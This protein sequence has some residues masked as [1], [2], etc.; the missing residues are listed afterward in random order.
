LLFCPLR[1]PQSGDWKSFGLAPGNCS[2]V[3]RR[4]GA[5]Q[6]PGARTCDQAEA[7]RLIRMEIDTQ[8]HKWHMGVS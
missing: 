8:K 4:H 1:N 2:E 7:G 5:I 3:A 6:R